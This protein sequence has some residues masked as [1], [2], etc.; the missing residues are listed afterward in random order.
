MSWFNI[1][2]P[3]KK[4]LNMTIPLYNTSLALLTDFYELIM[5]YSYWKTGMADHEAVFHQF[6]RRNPFKGGFTVASGLESVV[7]YLE[8]F[9]FDDSDIDY[10]ATL[11]ASDG[12]PYFEE[13]FFKYLRGM[14]F[15][16]DIDAVPEGSVIFPYEPMTRVTGPLIQCQLLEGPLLNLLNFSSLIS[17]K[18]ARVCIAAEREPV[19]EFGLRRA[20]GIDGS[21]TASRAAY[22]GGCES[23]SNTLAGKI[24]G[25]PAKGTLAHSW[26]MAFD[27]ELESFYTFAKAMPNNCVFL[28]DTY[29]SLEGVQKAIEVGHWL[30]KEGK[31]LLG[32]RLDSGD[33]AYLS[34]RSR[35]MLDQA[36]FND[37]KIYASNELDETIIGDLK[38]QG[39]KIAV[40]GVGT[41]LVTGK[42]QPWLDGVYKLSAIRKK[43][44][45][46]HYTLKLSEQMAKVSNPGIMQVKRFYNVNENIG[47]VIYDI[48]HEPTHEWIIVDPL[49]PTREKNISASSSSKDLL[50]PIFRKGELVYKLPS[51]NDIR[52]HAIKELDH[53]H[54]GIKRFIYPHQY[55]VGMEKWLYNHKIEL[56]KKIRKAKG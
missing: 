24:F 23:T 43:G 5:A 53:F 52:Q 29:D 47:D 8:N 7:K 39:A 11:K 17:T 2:A 33:L 41:N 54:S 21:L 16:C 15:S 28:V 3:L 45:D 48:N 32:I 14:R 37:A 50:Q 10:L 19:M 22:I 1:A 26:I 46:W 55:I 6:F 25:I 9:R 44:G 42:D 34:I 49:D 20:Q 51:L 4:H 35:E 31:K 18:A 12:S 56:I 27:D 13:G 36:G 40:W 38:K 30:K